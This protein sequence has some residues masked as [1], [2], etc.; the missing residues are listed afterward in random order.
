MCWTMKLPFW[1]VDTHQ[2]TSLSVTNHQSQSLLHPTTLHQT[3]LTKQHHPAVSVTIGCWRQLMRGRHQLLTL[4]QSYSAD[5]WSTSA[6]SVSELIHA[7]MSCLT[8]CPPLARAP[9]SWAHAA[10]AVP[11]APYKP[12]I[13]GGKT[14][15]TQPE[16]AFRKSL[17][18]MNHITTK[19]NIEQVLCM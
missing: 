18:S 15:H 16:H 2:Q 1:C 7:N 19:T 12:F 4:D 14:G 6:C 5:R 9:P 17:S 8:V 11:A 3:L 13:P 10:L